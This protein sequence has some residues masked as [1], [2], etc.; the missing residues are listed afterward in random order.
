[1]RFETIAIFVIYNENN[2]NTYA[3]SYD[4]VVSNNI[5]IESSSIKQSICI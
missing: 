1:M 4:D 3:F 5:C 2:D